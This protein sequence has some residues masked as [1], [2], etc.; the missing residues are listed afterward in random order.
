MT[1]NANALPKT[2][3]KKFDP[4]DIGNYP[5]R[6]VCIYELGLQSQRPYKGKE[7]PPRNEVMFTYELVSEFLQDEDG[8]DMEDKPRWISETFGF[9]PLTADMAKS[10][11]RYN[12]LDPK[13][14]HKGDF[15]KLIETPC[16]ITV[17]HNKAS[18]G[19]VYANVSAVTPPM[20]GMSYPELKNSP[21]VFDRT[22][23][24]MEV[25]EAMPEW[26]QK[27]IKE[28]LDFKSTTLF[29]KLTG[30]PPQERGEEKEDEG[31]PY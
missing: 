20:K 22:N 30:T 17:V 14:E 3:G 23:P 10:T 29:E 25:W 7:K 5:A 6:V 11:K 31:S 18:N 15:S 9:Y 21:K 27:K 2:G 26:I 19:N 8:N 1:L 24:D 28:G 12:V 16:T 4:V 13:N